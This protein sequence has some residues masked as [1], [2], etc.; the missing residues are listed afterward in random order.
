MK[1][2]CWLRFRF[3]NWQ[4]RSTQQIDV[5]RGDIAGRKVQ[6]GVETNVLRVCLD[7]G[8]SK[9]KTL[10]GSWEIEDLT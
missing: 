5:Y 10:Q 6:T 3:H 8:A 2:H 1:R 7:C 9:T 4:N